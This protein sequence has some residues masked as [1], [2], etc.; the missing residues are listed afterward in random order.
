[1]VLA[2]D[3][4]ST[5]YRLLINDNAN[6]AIFVRSRA[7][8]LLIEVNLER[9]KVNNHGA[10]MYVDSHSHISIINS[11]FKGTFH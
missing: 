2:D 1:M 6:R 4:N 7:S 3:S 10:A 9:N 8:V 11:N 5:L